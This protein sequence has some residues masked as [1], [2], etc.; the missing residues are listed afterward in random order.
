MMTKVITLCLICSCLFIPDASS[1]RALKVSRSEAY[2]E[3]RVALVIGNGDYASSPLK[4]P[5]NDATD[6]AAK[7]QNLGFEVTRLLNANQ[8]DM[9]RGIRDFGSRLKKG[10]VGLFYYAGHGMQVQGRNYLIP[11]GADIKEEDEVQDYAV[12]AAMVLRKMQ[13]AENRLNI[14]LL[15]ACRNNPYARSFRSMERGLAQMDAP[16]GSMISYATSPGNTALD[17]DGRNGL[18]TKH[19]LKT[20]DKSGNL[21]LS[22]LMKRVGK[23]VQTESGK[24]Q[25]PWVS[26][27]IT[28]DFFFN[29]KDPA[30][31]E[32]N[33]SLDRAPLKS[34]SL[35]EEEEFWLAIKN[36]TY[37]E[38]FK[39]YMAMYPD[40]RFKK[41]A[42]IKIR[43]LAPAKKTPEKKGP[44]PVT[45]ASSDKVLFHDTFDSNEN[46]WALWPNGEFY[47]TSIEGGVFA[48]ETRNELNSAEFLGRALALPEN[49]DIEVSVTWLNG[50]DDRSY[51]VSLGSDPQ[52]RYSFGVSGNGWAM[53][54]GY[55]NNQLLEPSPIPW[56]AGMAYVG[57]GRTKN[58]LRIQAR[59][60]SYSFYVNNMMVGTVF[61]PIPRSQIRLGFFV[62]NK[63]R[64]AFD[65]L[66]VKAVTHTGPP[67]FFDSFTDNAHGWNVWPNGEYYNAI[68]ENGAYAMETKNSMSSA[69]FP[70]DRIR[71]PENF[72]IQVT[73]TWKKGANN[74]SYG[75]ALGTEPQ[76]RYN[77]GVSAN[78]WSYVSAHRNN[79]VV[80][81]E[82]MPWKFGTVAVSDGF[83]QNQL[84]VQVRGTRC[85]YYV[86]NQL[87]GTVYITMPHDSLRVGLF[88]EN[89][90]KIYFDDLRVTVY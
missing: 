36:S 26:S 58:Q 31:Q 87:V 41:I 50:V 51:G 6:M 5:V 20:L 37:P 70:N 33:S 76:S 63:Q 25:V 16:S 22:Q 23:G 84:R 74:F 72:D 83:I 77:F 8:A 28:G 7:L 54:S 67:G 2:S 45:P 85:D 73:T 30:K 66:T 14:V 55:K 35:D 62:E 34:S 47:T 59:G 19:L 53:V 39:D 88:V 32:K 15:D 61:I 65:D 10:G 82:P 69:E 21:E 60:G 49:Y 64:I 44:L 86:N 71:L 81:P 3:Q 9:R 1:E 27:S 80:S 29:R 13:S 42:K 90:Q 52:N 40:G 11:V 56:K 12:D 4:N 75:I 57:N 48:M 43:Q 24:M 79:Q 38:D 17:G 78:G 46:A 18:F 89:M 68:F